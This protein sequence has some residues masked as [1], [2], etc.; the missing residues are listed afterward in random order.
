MKNILQKIQ[1]RF[2]AM[3]TGRPNYLAYQPNTLAYRTIEPSIADRDDGQRK[4]LAMSE[5]FLFGEDGWN[6]E[7]LIVWLRR[8][9]N[10]GVHLQQLL[11][12]AS[13]IKVDFVPEERT[14]IELFDH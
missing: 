11:D 4:S 2:R 5:L 7:A 13:T 14:T 12:L 6:E 10:P 1:D 8:S 3:V 9:R